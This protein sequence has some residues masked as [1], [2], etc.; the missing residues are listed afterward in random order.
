MLGV[1]N[2]GSFAGWT[3]IGSSNGDTVYAE[4]STTSRN[5]DAVNMRLLHDFSTEK[6]TQRN[7]YLSEKWLNAY[8][9]KTEEVRMSANF[10]FSE[11]MGSGDTVLSV[12]EFSYWK[13]VEPASVDY[14]SLKLACNRFDELIS[15][16][17]GLLNK[18]LPEN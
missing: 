7:N 3:A 1:F 16:G 11:N 5:G 4:S 10:F 8:D 15:F 17:K 6:I 12:E 13:L 18:I 14:S 9:C 2:N